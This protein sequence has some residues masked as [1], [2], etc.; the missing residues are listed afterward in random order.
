RLVSIT[1]PTLVL[2]GA[3][4]GMVPPENSRNLAS[5][6]PGARLVL[7]PQCGHLPMLEKP[8][9]VAGLVFEHLGV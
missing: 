2:C 9:T 6:I 1:V 7:I 3:D 4:D 8:E 5:R